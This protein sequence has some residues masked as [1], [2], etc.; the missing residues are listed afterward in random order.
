MAANMQQHMAGAG[1][2]MPQQ[3][4]KP[5][6]SQLQQAVYQNIQ[7]NTP[8]LNGMTWQSN[9][10]VNERMGKTLD[11]YVLSLRIY[12]LTLPSIP[13]TFTCGLQLT[14]PQNFQ[15]ISCYGHS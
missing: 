8:P 11:L 4:R 5:T 1:Q 6:A 14:F 12:P 9:F 2:M 10:S 13:L 3:L 15:H 7:Q